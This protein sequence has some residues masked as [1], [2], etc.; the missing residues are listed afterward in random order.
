LIIFETETGEKV[1]F[2]DGVRSQPARFD[3]EDRVRILYSPDD[4]TDA[5]VRGFFGLW[6]GATIVGGIGSVFLFIGTIFFFVRPD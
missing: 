5:M 3:P 2:I 1:E 4:P 6:G